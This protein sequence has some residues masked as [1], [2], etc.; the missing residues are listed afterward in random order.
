MGKH[1]VTLEKT[2]YYYIGEQ[3]GKFKVM[4]T[5]FMDDSTDL[6]RKAT[7]NMFTSSDEAQK[8]LDKINE[9]LKRKK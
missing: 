8:V 9:E 1:C 2:V 7:L 5:I 4:H 6:N 3:L